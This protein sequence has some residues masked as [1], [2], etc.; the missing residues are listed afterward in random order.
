M[1]TIGVVSDTHGILRG[2]ALEALRACDLI[3]H[4]G[5]IGSLEILERLRAICPVRAVRGNSDYGVVAEALP[6]TDV[7]DLSSPDGSLSQEGRGPMAYVL[8]GHEGLDLDPVA[9]GFRVVVSGHTHEP[10]IRDDGD[11]LYFNPGSAG[12]RRFSLPV[13]VG[14]LRIE[15]D[16][17]EAEIVDLEVL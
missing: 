2:E 14:R 5:D 15:G 16:M 12:P 1:R 13:T 10:L 11:V 3:I 17:V 7:V 6:A 9:S 8:H 4:A